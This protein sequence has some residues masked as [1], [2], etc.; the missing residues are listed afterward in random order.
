MTLNV[1]ND[2]SPPQGQQLC[3]I[4]LKEVAADNRLSPAILDQKRLLTTVTQDYYNYC[5]I[6]QPGPLLI[7]SGTWI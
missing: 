4:I 6:F 1:S 7:N 3:Q 2:T 5:N